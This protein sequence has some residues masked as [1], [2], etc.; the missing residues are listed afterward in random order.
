MSNEHLSNEPLRRLTLARTVERLDACRERTAAARE[1]L[2]LA[3]LGDLAARFNV[4]TAEGD[5][6]AALLEA[7]AAAP[8]ANETQRKAAAHAATAAHRAVVADCRA[9]L[10]AAGV[11]L[12]RAKTNLRL[13]EDERRSVEV[14]L[15]LWRDGL[16]PV[17]GPERVALADED[18]PF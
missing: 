10:L 13:A 3:E 6:A 1:A 16:L 11:E 8:G 9:R 2:L 18:I 14:V 7:T 12:A 15:G 4:E 5:L 17:G